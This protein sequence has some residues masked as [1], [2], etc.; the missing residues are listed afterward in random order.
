MSERCQIC[1]DVRPR[2]IE[3]HHILPRRFGGSDED[4]NLVAL[5]ASCHRAVESIYNKDFWIS[6]GL[7]PS[8]GSNT[9]DE[10]IERRLSLDRSHGV[11]PKSEVYDWY[12]DWCR[13]GDLEPAS[14]HMFARRLNRRQEV[15]SERA[16][17]AGEQC[18]CF[19]G[20]EKKPLVDAE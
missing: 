15:E 2:S 9:V 13:A 19:V 10:F 8:D 4:E 14:R 16:Y 7:R 3:E 5:C 17:V 1:G 18:R 12:T 6:V 20:I 11:T